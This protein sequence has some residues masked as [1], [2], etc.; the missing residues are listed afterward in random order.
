MRHFERKYI[1]GAICRPANGC[2]VTMRVWKVI[3]RKLW[4]KS[5]IS[6]DSGNLEQWH[7]LIFFCFIFFFVDELQLTLI[8]FVSYLSILRMFLFLDWLFSLWIK[9]WVGVRLYPTWCS[10]LP[11]L[12]RVYPPLP[13]VLQ[14]PVQLSDSW[15]AVY[16]V[17]YVINHSFIHQLMSRGELIDKWGHQ[18]S[19][20]ET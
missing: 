7:F 19:S 4:K 10:T 18:T 16:V 13:W 8:L 11:P 1:N 9:K 2:D 14:L 20:A 15:M 6:I 5:Q 17:N 12:F 3:W